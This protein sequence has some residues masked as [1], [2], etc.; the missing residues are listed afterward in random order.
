MNEKLNL[1]ETRLVYLS[2]NIAMFRQELQEYKDEQVSKPSFE[3]SPEII[4]LIKNT[5]N[6]FVENNIIGYLSTSHTASTSGDGFDIDIN[7]D[8]QDCVSDALPSI[9]RLAND[10]IDDLE[11]ELTSKQEAY[12]YEQSQ[13]TVARI[14]EHEDQQES[15]NN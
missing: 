9:Y 14:I 10:F 12:E 13:I 11:S 3:L 8:L 15:E 6:D 1:L 2:D 4:E 5:F 7:F